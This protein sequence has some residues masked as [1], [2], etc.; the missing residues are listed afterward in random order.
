MARGAEETVGG[1]GGQCGP[2]SSNGLPCLLRPTTM[3]T[4]F[5]IALTGLVWP[6]PQTQVARSNGL[7]WP[8]PQTQCCIALMGLLWPTP[9]AQVASSN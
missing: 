7:L 6:T 5:C 8:T 3:R 2:R 4:S 9:Q 1:G